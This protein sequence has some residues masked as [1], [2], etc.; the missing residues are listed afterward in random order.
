[1]FSQIFKLIAR[2]DFER[3]VKETAAQ[4]LLNDGK[5]LPNTR[6]HVVA[7]RGHGTRSRSQVRRANEILKLASAFF[8][9]AEL[10][11]RCK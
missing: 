2:S 8:A 11:R 7:I 4:P 9:E 6:G 3:I 10:D 5:R 1:M